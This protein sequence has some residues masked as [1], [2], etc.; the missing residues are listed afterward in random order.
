ML[1]KRNEKVLK[2]FKKAN[3]LQKAQM[4]KILKDETDN[5]LLLLIEMDKYR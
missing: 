1:N 3:D 5:L 4:Y 2:R